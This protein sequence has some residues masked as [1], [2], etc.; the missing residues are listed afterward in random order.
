MIRRLLAPM[1]LA[2]YLVSE[3]AW[4]PLKDKLTGWDERVEAAKR[5]GSW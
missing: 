1:N 4:L 5:R 2:V 3:W